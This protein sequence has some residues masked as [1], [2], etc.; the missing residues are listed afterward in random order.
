VLV[1]VCL[2]EPFD[3]VVRLAGGEGS[4]KSRRDEDDAGVV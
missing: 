3:I 4:I 1:D 2:I